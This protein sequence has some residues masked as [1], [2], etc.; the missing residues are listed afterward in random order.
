MTVGSFIDGYNSGGSGS[1]I[2][3]TGSAIHDGSWNRYMYPFLNNPT[4][5]NTNAPILIIWEDYFISCQPG[6]VQII[7]EI[8]KVLTGQN[9]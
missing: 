2:E 4:Q 6:R 9:P 8:P 5:T 7:R 1:K 3:L